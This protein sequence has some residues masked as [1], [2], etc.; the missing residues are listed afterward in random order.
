MGALDVAKKA[1]E[2]MRQLI[3]YASVKDVH[4]LIELIKSVGSTL[5]S[6]QPHELA[7][8]NMVRR[9]LAIVREESAAGG[10][11]EV[12]DGDGEGTGGGSSSEVGVPS[13]AVGPSLI[14]MLDAPQ[15]PDYSRRPLK[16]IKGQ[17]IEAIS[18][19]LDELQSAPT[20]IAEQAIEHIHSNEVILT[21]GHDPTVESFLRAAHKKRTFQVIVAET[22]PGGEGRLTAFELA[23]AGIN[24]TLIADAGV[25]AMMARVNKVI[26]GAHAVMANGGLMA[27]S[28]C[29]L[30]ALAAQHHAVPVVVCAGMYKLTPLFPSGP[31]PFNVL[32]S[33]QP[34][35]PYNEGLHAVDTPNPAFD[36]VPPELVS[37]L[38]TNIGGNHASYIYRL[39][40]QEYH[41]DDYEL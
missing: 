23:E 36:Y 5:M 20:H 24:T 12:G 14:K 39:L 25:F 19:L 2:I 18:E 33:P 13:A 35:L 15:Q 31:E 40:Q 1:V 28:G 3:G 6:A 4:G 26:V 38:I 16:A 37:L 9:V 11:V 32:L 34:M 10:E 29:H 30:L 7:I 27:R 41:P 21:H 8:G 17:M 22:A